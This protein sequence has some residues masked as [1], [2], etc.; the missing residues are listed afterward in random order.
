MLFKHFGFT[1]KHK[2]KNSDNNNIFIDTLKCTE[3]TFLVAHNINDKCSQR[4]FCEF[5]KNTNNITRF[6]LD[7]DLFYWETKVYMTL[8]DSNLFPLINAIENVIEYK[9]NTHISL[10][11]FL[12]SD[13]AKKID[14][15]K[16]ILVQLYNFVCS[17]KKY[18][19]VHGNLHLDNIFINKNTLD[20]QVIDFVNS[21]ILNCSF[22]YKFSRQS[23]ITNYVFKLE[24][25]DI[26]T[27][28]H[29]LIEFFEK[30][31][32]QIIFFIKNLFKN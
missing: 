2:E 6:Y 17:F 32:E 31:E 25:L 1:H 29:S 13:E 11:Q 18:Q 22:H 27:L 28:M 23:F 24:N 20:F 14:N 4:C 26:Y 15:L 9:L 8:I 7:R 5:N 10:R 21:H 12:Q 3:G 16:T 19:F 30:E